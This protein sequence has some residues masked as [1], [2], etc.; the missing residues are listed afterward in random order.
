MLRKCRNR[1]LG[2]INRMQQNFTRYHKILLS[3]F[4][5]EVKGQA[6]ELTLSRT[7]NFGILNRFLED[8]IIYIQLHISGS[9]W[10]ASRQFPNVL[11]MQIGG[12]ERAVSEFLL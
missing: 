11:K 4:L 10:A 6:F 1:I 5:L 2:E 8:C 12:S 3:E 9:F 7:L